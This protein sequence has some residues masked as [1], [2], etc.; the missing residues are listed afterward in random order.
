MCERVDEVRRV[1]L[2]ETG[3]QCRR[4]VQTALGRWVV[5]GGCWCGVLGSEV[6]VEVAVCFLSASEEAAALTTADGFGG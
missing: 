1:V 2:S 3:R 6:M 4:V 5:C